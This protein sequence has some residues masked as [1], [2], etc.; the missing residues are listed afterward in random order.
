MRHLPA[1]RQRHQA[2]CD[3]KPYPHIP[4]YHLNATPPPTRQASKS[5]NCS[6]NIAAVSPSLP[7]PH[8]SAANGNASHFASATSG[9]MSCADARPSISRVSFESMTASIRVVVAVQGPRTKD[10]E[11]TTNHPPPTTY[12]VTYG[13]PDCGEARYGNCDRYGTSLPDTPSVSCALMPVLNCGVS[14]VAP[15]ITRSA[16]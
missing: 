3:E 13:L 14:G 16:T 5:G 11:T 2:A 9:R 4:S 12:R 10:Q 6:T 8:A 7:I 15:A 1:K